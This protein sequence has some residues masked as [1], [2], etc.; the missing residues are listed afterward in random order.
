MKRQLDSFFE[1]VTRLVF[2]SDPPEKADAI[3]IPGSSRSGP[4]QIAARLFREGYAP[5]IIPSGKYGINKDSFRI[6]G[7]ETEADW[8]CDGLLCEGV[9]GSAIL[10]ERRAT[11]TWENARFSRELCD[12]NGLN[13]SK[14][15]LCCRPF[16]ARRA[17][18]YYQTAFPETEW[19]AC[20][21]SEDGVNADDWFRT[22]EGRKRVLGELRR[23]GDQINEQLEELIRHG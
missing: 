10:M 18:L 7:F 22:P 1:E 13:I 9:P 16:H 14:G 3:F 19:I 21:S 15:I 23:L 4:L 11:F 8:M 2:V 20:P 12:Q 17:L 5:V 6:P